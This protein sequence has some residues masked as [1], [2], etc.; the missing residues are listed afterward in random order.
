MTGASFLAKNKDYQAKPTL[1]Q[2]LGPSVPGIKDIG[3]G[4]I[5]LGPPC[6]HRK[7]FRE[8]AV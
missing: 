4:A 1:L 3:H 7:K 5:F 2:V 6:D 8:Y